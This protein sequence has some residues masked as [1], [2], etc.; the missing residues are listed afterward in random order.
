MAPFRQALADATQA[1]GSDGIN[2]IVESN[3]LMQFVKP[4]LYVMVLDTARDDFKD[5]ARQILG[6]A[7]AFVFRGGLDDGALNHPPGLQLPP[8]LVRPKPSVHQPDG[9]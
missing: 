5:S 4:S 8:K 3:S 1:N 7:D 9:E 6:R 2:V